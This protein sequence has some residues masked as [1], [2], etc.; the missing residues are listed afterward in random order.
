MKMPPGTPRS[1]SLTRL[2]MRVALPH[3]GQSVLFVVSISFLRSAVLA[4][5]AICIFSG[6]T[7]LFSHGKPRKDTGTNCNGMRNFEQKGRNRR[8]PGPHVYFT[9]AGP[10]CPC[11][12]LDIAP[13]MGYQSD[14][15]KLILSLLIV[16][17]ASA[18]AAD[19]A[20]KGYLVD[21]A[22]AS[23]E[24]QTPGFGAKH[25]KGCL[26]LPDCEKSGYA[27]LTEDKTVIRFNQDGKD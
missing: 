5:L 26:P 18:F 22:C 3:W 21:I 14:M 17:A 13:A 4:I 1:R 12:R 15:K 7:S 9:L 2:T 27:V 24:R 10:R 23:E 20:V 6:L 16:I 25:S 11:K 8:L 19:S